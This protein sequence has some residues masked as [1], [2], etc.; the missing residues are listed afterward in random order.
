MPKQGILHD[1]DLHANMELTAQGK[2]VIFVEIIQ[3]LSSGAIILAK[4]CAENAGILI[5]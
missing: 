4:Q 1:Y 2:L 3:C 5:N